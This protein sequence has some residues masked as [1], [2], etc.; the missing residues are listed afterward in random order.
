MLKVL[1]AIINREKG[2]LK[3]R[4]RTLWRELAF[5]ANDSP[6]T[7]WINKETKSGKLTVDLLKDLEIL[8][9]IGDIDLPYYA[10][11]LDKNRNILRSHLLRRLV[12]KQLNNIHEDLIKIDHE[13]FERE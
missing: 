5:V 9:V 6:T 11:L 3:Q 8:K 1:T 7:T 12:E 4:A 10:G 13:L 2:V